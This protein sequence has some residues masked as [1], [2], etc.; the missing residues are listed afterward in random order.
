MVI[1][2]VLLE[3]QLQELNDE[4]INE[5]ETKNVNTDW[6]EQIGIL[7][8]KYVP[9]QCRQDK[10]IGNGAAFDQADPSTMCRAF[11]LVRHTIAENEPNF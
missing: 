10:Y 8:P 11:E 1:F 9:W 2:F 6:V 4:D 3:A 5:N 7:A